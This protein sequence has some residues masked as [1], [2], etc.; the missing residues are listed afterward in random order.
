MLC[1][2]CQSEP[3]CETAPAPDDRRRIR[4]C[5]R[6]GAAILMLE[7]VAVGVGDGTLAHLARFGLAST[8]LPLLETSPERGRPV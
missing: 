8:G 5:D 1:K 2:A 6:C 3:G 4:R 7:G